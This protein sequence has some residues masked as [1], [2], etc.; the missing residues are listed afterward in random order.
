MRWDQR[1]RVG[2]TTSASHNPHRAH[3][4]RARTV[5]AT[6]LV[7]ADDLNIESLVGELVAFAG[8]RPIFDATTGAAGES[9]RRCRP[10]VSLLDT[11]LPREVLSACLFASDEVGAQPI[12]IS[13]TSSVEELA[14]RA[15]REGCLYF[16]LPG[17]PRAL[18]HVIDRAVEREPRRVEIPVSHESS[19]V[20]PALCAAIASVGRA[21]ALALAA[22]S[23]VRTTRQLRADMGTALLE[24]R[25][26]RDA[27]R[28]AVA[29]Y[30]THLRA[31]AV[32]PERAVEIVTTAIAD[33]AG[34]VGAEL[35]VA[36]LVS[37]FRGWALEAYALP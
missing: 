5:V 16:A 14:V 20:H 13:S 15:E 6:I 23:T 7:I 31:E 4:V 25:R 2:D 10:D 28:A 11:A 8:H 22:Q 36:P 12:L 35:A 29:D 1:L 30:A 18:E 27:L 17:G 33:C 3:N 34:V 24:A 9:I 19:P 37:D 32:P 26:S 21:R